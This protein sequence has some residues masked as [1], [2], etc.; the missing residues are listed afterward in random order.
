MTLPAPVDRLWHLATVV[1]LACAS[2]ACGVDMD[3]DVAEAYASLPPTL[4]YNIDVRPILSDRCWSCHGPDARARMAD[5]RLDDAESAYA[6]T[7]LRSPA[8][9]PGKAGSSQLVSRILSHDPE[10]LMPTPESHMTL[11]AYEKAVLVKWIE[12]GAQYDPHWAF[13]PLPPID[14]AEALAPGPIDAFVAAAQAKHQLTSN[15][16]A[17]PRELIRRVYRDLTGLPPTF[18]QTQAFVNDPSDAHYDRLVDSLLSTDATAERLA[19]E[20]MD[21]ARYADSH[22]LHADGIRTMWPWRDWVIDA[23]RQNKSYRSFVTEQLAGDLMPDATREQVLA[24]AFNRNHPMTAEG[25]ANDEEFRTQYVMDRANTFATAFLGLTMECAACHDHKFDPVSQ[26]EYYQLTAFF[27]NVKEAGMTGD[28]GDFGPLLSLPDSATEA[29][30]R[31]LD[32]RIAEL[33]ASTV[34]VA[35]QIAFIQGLAALPKP[36]AYLPLDAQRNKVADGYPKSNILDTL[37]TVPG[38]K[39]QAYVFDTEWDAVDIP[40]PAFEA[41]DPFSLSLF[42]NTTK[43]RE[44]EGEWQCLLSNSGD[45]NG[46]WRGFN[47][48]LMP[49]GRLNLRV[50]HSLP[51]NY[52]EISTTDKVRLNT[53]THVAATYDGSLSAKGLRIY[54]D[55]QPVKT[56]IDFDRLNRTTAP[57]TNDSYKQPLARPIRLAVSG[58]HYKGE[59]GIFEGAIDE[60]YV[61]GDQLSALEMGQLA[62]SAS[63]KLK[64]G[65][66]ASADHERV[67]AWRQTANKVRALRKEKLEAFAKTND[68]MVMTEMAVPRATHVLLRGSFDQFGERVDYGT[69]LAIGGFDAEQ[70]PSNRL[71]LSEWLF[72]EDNPLTARVAV[73]RYWQLLM[74]RGLVATPHDFGMQGKL[75]SHPELL[76][77]L[78]NGFRASD[79]DL[80]AL[81][82]AI[83]TSETYKVSSQVNAENRTADPDNVYLT[84]ATSQRYRAE[85]IR[86]YALAVSGLLVDQVGGPSVYPYEPAGLWLEKASFSKALYDYRVQSGD[87]LYRRSMYTIVRR[88]SP[89]PAMV[90]LDMPMR[91]RCVVYRETTNTPLQAL[92]LLNDPQYVE[93]ARVLAQAVDP[94]KSSAVADD[95]ERLFQEVLGRHPM[96]SE[97]AALD[98]VYASAVKRFGESPSAATELLAVGQYPRPVKYDRT[99]LAALTTVANTVLN[100][101]EV[102]TRR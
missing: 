67:T 53:W 78:A 62:Q 89:P 40:L 68:V 2:V 93:A 9:V 70:Y 63:A 34:P 41:Y 55:G 85:M 13:V 90:T 71:G 52:L 92:V 22:G 82:R 27:N 97:V 83:V 79:Y 72:A 46:D 21:V 8:I 94:M 101:D 3:A 47:F 56:I 64:P 39:G 12:D 31:Q 11:D 102:Y 16:R 69:P 77:Y 44:K 45:K 95:I 84:R 100:H 1:L 42:I 76:D 65:P 4:D 96:P 57:I 30:L 26:K 58:R 32:A 15:E 60:V 29:K 5:L 73:N 43:R 25:G 10:Y 17:R 66:N 6:K 49:D 37:Y 38:V 23:F 14:E 61:F 86:D 19:S 98:K 35:K 20:W 81:L 80:H 88:T 87:S 24:T 91:D 99:H 75:P 28:D 54:V 7:D 74:G 50:T 18:A 59:T 36:L 51:G 48:E 33:S